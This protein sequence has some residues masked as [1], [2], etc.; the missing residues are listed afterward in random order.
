[1]KQMRSLLVLVVMLSLAA[2]A[3]AEEPRIDVDKLPIDIARITEALQESTFREERDGLRLRYFLNI[4]A[5][6]PPLNIVINPDGRDSW[7]V[8]PVP[9]TAPT[10]KELMDFVTPQEFRTP[11]IDLAALQQWLADKSSKK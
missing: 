10:H 6:A 5:Q 1:M 3:A 7:L 2:P 4:N 8:G 9:H 11:A